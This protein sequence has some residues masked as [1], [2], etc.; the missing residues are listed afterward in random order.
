MLYSHPF[1]FIF[2]HK[3]HE[4]FIND[5]FLFCLITI[6]TTKNEHK[7]LYTIIFMMDIKFCSIFVFV[8]GS[9]ERRRESMFYTFKVRQ[10]LLTLF[11]ICFYMYIY[12]FGKQNPKILTFFF[13][14]LLPKLNLYRDMQIFSFIYIKIKLQQ[15]ID[16]VPTL[17]YNVY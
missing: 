14:N 3:F 2:A 12:Q 16:I 7:H 13:Q 9:P 5:F 4:M 6:I 10:C 15:N 8:G 11:L 1:A 17:V